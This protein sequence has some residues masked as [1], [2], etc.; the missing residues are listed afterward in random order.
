MGQSR[1]SASSLA[2][3]KSLMNLPAACLTSRWIRPEQTPST[4][5]GVNA[6]G[7]AVQVDLPAGRVRREAKRSLRIVHLDG[8]D[9]VVLGRRGVDGP[10]DGLVA[11]TAQ[12]DDV[13]AQG[14]VRDLGAGRGT[15][16]LE[17]LARAGSKKSG[18][19]QP[20]VVRRSSPSIQT[21]TP[22]GLGDEEGAGQGPDEL[23]LERLRVPRSDADRPGLG[24]VA[25]LRDLHRVV[26][27]QDLEGEEVGEPERSCARPPETERHLGPRRLRGHGQV[28]DQRLLDEIEDVDHL[29]RDLVLAQGV[30]GLD[31]DELS[32]VRRRLLLE[33]EVEVGA[34]PEL[35]GLDQDVPPRR[36]KA[37]LALHASRRA[38]MSSKRTI[39]RL[40]LGPSN[41]AMARASWSCAACTSRD[42]PGL[43]RRPRRRRGPPGAA[44]QRREKGARTRRAAGPVEGS[45]SHARRSSTI[46]EDLLRPVVADEDGAGGV[47]G[48]GLGPPQLRA[49]RA[50]AGA[51]PGARR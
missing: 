35:V 48:D 20:A 21:S 44:G 15:G 10:P 40:W 41:S 34:G 30:V 49:R 4:S 27:G 37:A 42:R 19:R 31:L 9:L 14:E 38:M 6:L 45:C 32:E 23:D 46:P 29:G 50:C 28:A 26:A 43:G 33:P 22:G 12:L 11:A 51:G 39:E 25:L 7:L 47:E 36:G 1:V 13:R 18:A 17:P 8:V 3:V 24:L 2:R 16:G 5:A